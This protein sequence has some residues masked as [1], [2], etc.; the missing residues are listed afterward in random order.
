MLPQPRTG[1]T[2]AAPKHRPWPTT[3]S[4][5]GATE[6]KPRMTTPRNM[7]SSTSGATTTA[8]MRKAISTPRSPE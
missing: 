5:T 6:A 2:W 1:S 7:S 8:T 3:A 4:H